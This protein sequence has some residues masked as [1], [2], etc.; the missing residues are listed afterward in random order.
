MRR[1]RQMRQKERCQ[2]HRR[3]PSCYINWAVLV[4]RW[5]CLS[6]DCLLAFVQG[7]LPLPEREIIESHVDGCRSCFRL[8]GAAMRLA[9]AAPE[10]PVEEADEGAPDFLDSA[11]DDWRA[12]RGSRAHR[13]RRRR[14]GVPSLRC[15]LKRA[16]AFKIVRAP[17]GKPG[18]VESMQAR[19]LREARA[20]AQISHP[21]VVTVYDVGSIEGSRLHR[22]GAGRWSHA[23]AVDQRTPP[24]VARHRG[25]VHPGWARSRRRSRGRARSPRF[26]TAQRA[27]RH[28]WP[29][30]SDRLRPRATCSTR[31][32]C[33]LDSR[34]P[35]PAAKFAANGRSREPKASSAP[36]RSWLPSSSPARRSMRAAINSASVWLFFRRSTVAIRSHPREPSAL[37]SP[38]S[39]CGW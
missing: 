28:R 12:L 31:R 38:S 21:H 34:R 14:S 15:Q 2:M 33:G 36:P 6:D 24:H 17:R 37:Q 39:R 1:G 35:R 19:L 5:K 22:H 13:P 25:H 11:H 23:R 30:S 7:E 9:P 3:Y 32:R 8:V 29:S 20:M 16:I 27:R 4:H 26:Q 10:G 18:D